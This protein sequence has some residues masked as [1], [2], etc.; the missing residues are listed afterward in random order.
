MPPFSEPM[1]AQDTAAI[2]WTFAAGRVRGRLL[3]ESDDDRALYVALYAEPVVMAHIGAAM[4]PAAAA[5]LFQKSVDC[6]RAPAALARYWRVDEIRT[7]EA[8]GIVALVRNPNALDRGE[9][10]VMLR[11]H[12]QNRGVGLPALAGL[13]DGVIADRW[14]RDVD[15]LIGRHAADNPNAG[16]LTEAL[17]FERQADDGSG[18]VRWYLKRSDWHL[19][20]EA[21]PSA[22]AGIRHS[23][24]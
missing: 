16:R 14:L 20:R 7:G 10:G 4:S 23:S 2:D 9:L 18:S 19:R 11:P 17:G 13:V 22:A 12:W 21:W 8:V 24:N 3:D 1:P 6:N 15:L 5:A